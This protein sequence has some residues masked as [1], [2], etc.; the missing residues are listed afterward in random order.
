M[1][2][3]RIDDDFRE[4]VRDKEKGEGRE[5]FVDRISLA[6]KSQAKLRSQVSVTSR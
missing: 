1:T 3:E 5:S 2:K 4:K 6:A